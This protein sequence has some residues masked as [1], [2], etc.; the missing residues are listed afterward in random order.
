MTKQTEQTI[1][2]Q[3]KTIH[4]LLELADQIWDAGAFDYMIDEWRQNPK[5]SGHD[6]QMIS[7]FLHLR[8]EIKETKKKH[9]DTY[10]R[11]IAGQ[12]P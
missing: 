1:L 4:E 9:S 7:W 2:N 6:E 12:K 5:S 10:R 11:F 8:A 3:N